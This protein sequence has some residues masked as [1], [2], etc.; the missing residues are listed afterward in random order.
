MAKEFTGKWVGHYTYGP[1]Y[2][3]GVRGGKVKVYRNLWTMGEFEEIRVGED[4]SV[5]E[6]VGRGSW[7]MG[8]GNE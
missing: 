5:E 4:G 2:Q 6:R 3:Q 7:R 8:R 1:S